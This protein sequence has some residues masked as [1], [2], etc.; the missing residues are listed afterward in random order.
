VTC[1]IERPVL[2]IC[3]IYRAVQIIETLGSDGPP[4]AMARF[5]KVSIRAARSRVSTLTQLGRTTA[6]CV[7]LIMN[8]ES[9]DKRDDESIRIPNARNNE[10]E[11]IA[12]LRSC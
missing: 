3:G 1:K 4:S 6:F 11:K 7:Y 10:D 8:K 12:N 2:V 9:K 5:L